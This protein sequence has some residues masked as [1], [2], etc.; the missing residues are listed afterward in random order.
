MG[1]A[2][3][4]PGF[5]I[6]VNRIAHIDPVTGITLLSIIIVDYREGCDRQHSREMVPSVN[7]QRE[8]P[9]IGE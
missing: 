1:E 4:R 2:H 5:Q 3:G 6:P 9:K 7:C 8:L